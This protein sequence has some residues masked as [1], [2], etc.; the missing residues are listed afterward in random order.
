MRDKKEVENV[1]PQSRSSPP[2]KKGKIPHE[3][4]KNAVVLNC[5]VQ[6]KNC[7]LQEEL[8]VPGVEEL[9]LTDG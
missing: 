2:N 5:L 4:V 1:T 7:C 3:T 6:V 9:T 8:S